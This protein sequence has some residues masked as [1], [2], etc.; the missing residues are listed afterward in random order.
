MIPGQKDAEYV[1]SLVGDTES[2]SIEAT[3]RKVGFNRLGLATVFIEG[4]GTH[5][6]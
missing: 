1:L 2:L 5:F 4:Q 3:V 6:E